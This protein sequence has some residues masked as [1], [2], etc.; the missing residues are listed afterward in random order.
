VE[1]TLVKFDHD[2]KKAYLNLKAEELLEVLQVEEN[3]N[4]G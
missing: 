1:Y 2:K 4:L 3:K